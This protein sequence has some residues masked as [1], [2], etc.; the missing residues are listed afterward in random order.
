MYEDVR[1]EQNGHQRSGRSGISSTSRRSMLGG[2]GKDRRR[3]W[4]DLQERPGGFGKAA[5]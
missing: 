3:S 4:P 1:I 5:G 2:A